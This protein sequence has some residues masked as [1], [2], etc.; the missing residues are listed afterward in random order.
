VTSTVRVCPHC[1]WQR[2]EPGLVP[3]GALDD[4]RRALAIAAPPE[5][6]AVVA[7]PVSTLAA[8]TAELEALREAAGS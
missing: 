1:G 3:A 5:G 7:M 8:L 4:A 2:R 6:G